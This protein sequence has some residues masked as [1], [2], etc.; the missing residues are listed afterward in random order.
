ME[1]SGIKYVAVRNALVERVRQ[2]SPGDRLPSETA[3]CAEFGVSR[4][5][6]R[7]AVDELIREGLVSR[8]QGRGT[9]VRAPAYPGV[10]TESFANRVTG[11]YR[12]QRAMGRH[13]TTRVVRNE[14]VR[15]AVPAAALGL[16]P[17]HELTRLD[18]IRYVNG[19]LQQYSS[20]WL[21]AKR[22]PEVAGADFTHGSLY[23]FL[24]H[25]CA[26]LL[27]RNDLVVRVDRASIEA[28]DALDIPVGEPVLAMRSTV[29]LGDDTPVAFGE[30][31]FAPESSEVAISLRELGVGGLRTM[32]ATVLENTRSR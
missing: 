31:T 15:E 30:T 8:E 5:T 29:F 17:A 24:E 32:V 3:L 1:L 27:M 23:E 10:F 21:S 14:R 2:S 19:S 20:T 12:Q 13:V 6:V 4:I 26:V 9:F 16:P 11:F 7:R 28:A 25:E 18:R 22:Y